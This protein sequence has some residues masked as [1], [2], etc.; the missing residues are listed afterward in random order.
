MERLT[1]E[2]DGVAS[3]YRSLKRSES[4]HQHLLAGRRE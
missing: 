1:P 2:F 3:D 4:L